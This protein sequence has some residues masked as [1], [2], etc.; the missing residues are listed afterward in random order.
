MKKLTNAFVKKSIE[1]MGGVLLSEYID[2][3]L[4][5]KVK[6]NVCN[7][8]WFPTWDNLRHGSWCKNCRTIKNAKRNRLGFKY[9][10]EQISIKGGELLSDEY[11]NSSTKLKI[12]CNVCK[13]IWYPIYDNI[14]VGKWCPICCSVGKGQKKL[15]N[16]I[17]DIFYCENIKTNYRGFWW[18]YNKKTKGTQEID[19]WIPKLKIAIEYDGIQ[20]FYP[21]NFGGVSVERAEKNFKRTKYNDRR[22]NRLMKKYS[23]DVKYFIRF[24]YK[25]PMTKEYVVKKLIK[26]GVIRNA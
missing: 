14:R 11:I 19:I 24:N 5:L 9:V 3:G 18:L 17:Q 22:K 15:L 20:H 25:E 12:K 13:H 2:S 4:K 26:Y 10:S 7:E 1:K 6:C 16:V 8:V 23:E 21:R